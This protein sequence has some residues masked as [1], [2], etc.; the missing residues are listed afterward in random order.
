MWYPGAN[1]D[2]AVFARPDV[3]DIHRQPTEPLAFAEGQHF[4]TPTPM[5][6]VGRSDR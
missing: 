5:P 6:A 3:F 2:E 1:C 4:C